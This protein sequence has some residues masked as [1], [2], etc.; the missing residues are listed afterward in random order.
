ML[1]SQFVLLLILIF[2]SLLIYREIISYIMASEADR[3]FK[4]S[5]AED[6]LIKYLTHIKHA[7]Y[8]EILLILLCVFFCCNISRKNTG[9][10][11]H[12]AQSV[13]II[14]VIL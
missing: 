1:K 9:N 11:F 8:H 7:R 5:E 10:S 2:Q 6:A 14:H 4:S 3:K 12:S 13:C